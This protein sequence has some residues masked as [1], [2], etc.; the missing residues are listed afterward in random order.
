MNEQ[1][2]NPAI[3]QQRV[4]DAAGL[5]G[6]GCVTTGVALLSVPWGLIVFGTALLGLSLW[7]AL[8]SDRNTARNP[9]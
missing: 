6:L 9:Q 1:K 5:V 7:G 4:R 8:R 2:P 3:R